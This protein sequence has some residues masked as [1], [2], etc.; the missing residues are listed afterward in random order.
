L[1]KFVQSIN[2]DHAETSSEEKNKEIIKILDLQKAEIIGKI[3]NLKSLNTTTNGAKTT[4]GNR[5]E[6]IIK[7]LDLQKAEIVEKIDDLRS[8][9]AS[10]GGDLMNTLIV[11]RNLCGISFQ[12]LEEYI[13]DGVSDKDDDNVE[14]ETSQNKKSNE[15]KKDAEV[16]REYDDNNIDFK[17]EE[18]EENEEEEIEGEEE[19]EEGEEDEGEEEIEEGE[20]EE[21][22]SEDEEENE[23]ESEEEESEEE[24]SEEEQYEEES[25]V[26]EEGNKK[27][28]E[29]ATEAVQEN[30]LDDQD[31]D[32]D[33]NVDVGEI[34]DNP[35]DQPN[36][37][38]LPALSFDDF[39]LG[40]E[41]KNNNEVKEKIRILKEKINGDEKK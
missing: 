17:A 27:I 28:V 34:Q 29:S 4:E 6:E 23:E 21:D 15:G 39:L 30:N 9:V 11:F 19:S 16:S 14:E 12:K 20:G 38:E 24:E 3:D 35:E 32:M 41:E 25:N 18:E 36:S 37:S 26:R 22:W 40:G 7:I 1:E 31:I 8:F 5:S 2:G 13:V 33:L 10:N